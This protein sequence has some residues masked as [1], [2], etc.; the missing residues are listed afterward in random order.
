MN[1]LQGAHPLFLDF[2]VSSPNLGLRIPIISEDEWFK[3]IYVMPCTSYPT[4]QVV[5]DG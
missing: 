2:T 4:N 5:T 3:L 1:R